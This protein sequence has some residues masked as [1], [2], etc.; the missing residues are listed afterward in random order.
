LDDSSMP[1]SVEVLNRP[2]FQEPTQIT[3]ARYARSQMSQMDSVC[4]NCDRT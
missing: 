4:R 2:R 1:V 3:Q